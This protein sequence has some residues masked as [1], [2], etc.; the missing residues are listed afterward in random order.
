VSPGE[1]IEYEVPD[2]YGR[3]WDAIW[4]KYFEQGM[5]VTVIVRSRWRKLRV[6]RLH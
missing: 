5:S 3:P 6:T 2:M 1:T 4:R